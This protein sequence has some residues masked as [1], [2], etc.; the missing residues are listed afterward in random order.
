MSFLS[1]ISSI[2]GPL[3]A[4]RH[5]AKVNNCR[6]FNYQDG[7][8]RFPVPEDKVSW[9]VDWPEYQPVDHTH[10]AVLRGPVW[11]D[12]D[13][14]KVTPDT[15]PKYNEL[16][17]NV[18]RK[19]YSGTYEIVNGLPRNP[20][21]R[22]GMCGRGL[23]GRWGPNHAVDPIVSRWKRGEDGA[24][25]MMEG[26]PVLEFVAIM[27]NDTRDWAI[28]GGMIDPG[29]TVSRTLRKEFGE[30]AM[31]SLEAT[32][33]EKKEIEAHVNDLFKAG[34]EVYSG[35]VDDIRNTDNSWM[36]T[37]AMNFH[38]ET[39]STF[40]KIKLKA[41]DDAGDVCWMEASSKLN[42]YASHL[43][44]IE[45]VVKQRNAAW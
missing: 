7:V 3:I 10:P 14:R 36:E 19:S 11:A 5:M 37:V 26:K 2:T 21:G 20:I 15:P 18:D 43:D 32:E 8:K 24:K 44:F 23:L 33:E 29:D 41:G 42:L 31:N 6:L 35:Y 38:D 1:R 4:V 45:T 25:T 17:G 34:D 13:F 12:L 16:D 39:G 28:P 9:S 30:E 27:R 22:T 40:N